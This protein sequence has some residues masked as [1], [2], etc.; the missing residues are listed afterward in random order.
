MSWLRC[1]HLLIEPAEIREL[2]QA[3]LLRGQPRFRTRRVWRALSSHRDAAFDLTEAQ[4]A[5]L[6]RASPR[7]PQATEVLRG[8][9]SEAEWQALLD[10]GFLRAATAEDHAAVGDVA[11]HPLAAVLHRQCRWSDVDSRETDARLEAVGGMAGLEA[12]FGPVPDSHLGCLDPTQR[13]ALPVAASTALATSLQQR[14][15]CRNFDQTRAVALQDLATVLGQVY[16]VQAEAEVSGLQALK[17]LVPSAGGLHPVE[18]FVL[19]QHI[20]GLAPGLYHYHCVA[21]ALEPLQTLSSEAV[22]DLAARCVAHQTW[23]EDAPVLIFLICRFQRTFWKYRE[24]AKAYR[25]VTVDVGHLS[26][27]QYAVAT[28]LGLGSFFTAAINEMEIERALNLDP[29]Q[30][31]VMAVTGLGWRA[32]QMQ[33][34]EFDPLRKVWPAWSGETSVALDA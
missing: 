16:G 1:P 9:A 11:W 24:H 5:V 29:M 8:A 14:S 2:D 30:T 17:K 12:L 31:G 10:A 33:S 20:D 15:T 26:M 21:H 7:E 6:G 34:L 19:A 22:R 32:A 3:A 27:L 25:A 13:L 4:L 18:A 28:E 23:F